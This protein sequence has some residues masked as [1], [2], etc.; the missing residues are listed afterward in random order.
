MKKEKFELTKWLPIC[1]IAIILMLIYK[2]IDNLGQITSAIGEF[3]IVLSPLLYGILFTYFLLIPHRAIERLLLKSK[4]ALI[5]KHARGITT[6]LIFLVLIIIFAVILS[7]ILPIIFSNIVAFADSV[8]E[9]FS[10]ILAYFDNL[11]EDSILYSLDIANTLRNSSGDILQTLVNPDGIGQVAQGIMGVLGGIFSVIMG[12]V[13]SLYILLDRD[14]ILA[15]SKRLNRAIFKREERISRSIKYFAQ[16]NK[17][18]L[19]FIAS[20]G[21]DSLI[22]FI[23]ATTILLILGVPY[24]YLLGLIAG[25]FNFIPYIGSIISAFVISLIA[26][27]AVDVRTGLI[28]MLCLLVFHQL[29]GNYMEPRIMKSSLKISP[30]LVIIAVVIGGAYFGIVGMFL[31]VP[32]AVIIKELLLEYITFTELDKVDEIEKR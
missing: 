14:R 31:A 10:T 26:L 15:Y 29:D 21:L 1:I 20:K 25:I 7:F 28:V 22:N 6:I 16:I 27:I 24:A 8:P 13:I 18:L 9:Y 30:I 12:L 32:I 19:T 5:S 2:T 3:L 23:S 17:V 4:A 11:P